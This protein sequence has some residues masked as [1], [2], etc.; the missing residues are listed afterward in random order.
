MFKQRLQ[1]LDTKSWFWFGEPEEKCYCTPKLV[2]GINPMGFQAPETVVL[3][4]MLGTDAVHKEKR[5][6]KASWTQD[7]FINMVF[8]KQ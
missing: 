1:T 3:L 5:K 6:K 7:V 4:L 2:Y 8:G